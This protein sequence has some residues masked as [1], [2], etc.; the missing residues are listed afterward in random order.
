MKPK[1]DKFDVGIIVGRFQVAEL[2]EAHRELIDS[3]R[4][5]HSRT[6]IVLGLS[7]V[8]GTRNNPLGFQPRRQMIQEH[9]PDIDVVYIRD[10]KSDAKWSRE[11]DVIV[12]DVI[13][14]NSSAMLYGSR[15]SFIRCYNG[16]FPTTELIATKVVSGSDIRA[17]LSRKA[18]PSYDWRAGA[19]WQAFNQYRKVYP[20][21]DMAIRRDGKFLFVKKPDEAKWRFPGGFAADSNSYEQDATRE[22]KEETGLHCENPVYIGSFRINDWRYAGEVDCIKTLFFMLDSL[23]PNETAK[24]DDDVDKCEWFFLHD[25]KTD[26]IEPEHRLLFSALIDHLNR[27]KES[28]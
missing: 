12:R 8:S 9:Y 15:D 28:V 1:S 13:G 2:H 11:L 3:V 5:M 16:K 14:P 23:V 22:A 26:D 17:E 25:L 19:I 18:K 10:M 21:V 4:A 6:V 20:T 7:P 24:A 27:K